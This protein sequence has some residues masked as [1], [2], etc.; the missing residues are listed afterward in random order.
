MSMCNVGKRKSPLPGTHSKEKKKQKQN[1]ARRDETAHSLASGRVVRCVSDSQQYH[2]N[3]S[4][5]FVTSVG[6]LRRCLAVPHETK[7]HAARYRDMLRSYHDPWV[8]TVCGADAVFDSSKTGS[9]LTPLFPL[10]LCL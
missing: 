4:S 3:Y 7:F 6:H 5:P 1:E 8:K 10:M 2:L 9:R